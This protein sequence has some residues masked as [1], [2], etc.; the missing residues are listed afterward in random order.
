MLFLVSLEPIA[1]I[2]RKGKIGGGGWVHP[3]GANNMAM[4]GL[5]SRSNLVGT[6]VAISVLFGLNGVRNKQSHLVGPPFPVF[7]AHFSATAS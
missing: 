6:G 2:S 4:S 7:K 5:L 1:P 3:K